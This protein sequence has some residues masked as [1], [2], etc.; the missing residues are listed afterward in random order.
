MPQ[1]LSLSWPSHTHTEQPSVS[2]HLPDCLGPIHPL[3]LLPHSPFK[4]PSHLSK[5]KD[6]AQTP[7]LP[8]EKGKLEFT[9]LTNVPLC[10]SLT[11]PAHPAGPNLG[12][13]GRSSSRNAVLTEQVGTRSGRAQVDPG[14]RPV[15]SPGMLPRQIG[16]VD[17]RIHHAGEGAASLSN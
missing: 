17:F 13:V 16:R 4:T 14:S 3:S 12:T 10:L 1:S 6:G 9:T 11:K 2:F 7:L 8:V 5:S 15:F